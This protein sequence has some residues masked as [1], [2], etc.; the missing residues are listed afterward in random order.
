MK[1]LLVSCLVAAF[2]ACL[3]VGDPALV[4][5]PLEDAVP[6]GELSFATH[7]A[8]ILA[9]RGCPDC[10]T[11]GGDGEGHLDSTSATGFLE[12]GDSGPA[13]IACDH[14]N[15]YMWKRV[16]DCEMPQTGDCLNAIEIATIAKWIDQGGQATYTA[17]ACENPPLD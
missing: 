16:R 10:H 4:Q 2:P 14:E 11:A 8:P 13:I 7:V 9:R 17:G 5:E 1:R 3:D 6:S 12:G 15:S